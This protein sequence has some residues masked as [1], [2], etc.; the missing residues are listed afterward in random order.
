[1]P[2]K[3]TPPPARP[4][5]TSVPLTAATPAQALELPSA[6]ST[7]QH[8]Y[9]DPNLSITSNVD[10]QPSEFVTQRLKRR[11]EEH[12]IL[13]EDQLDDFKREMFTLFRELKAGQQAH[14]VAL[15]SAKVELS[16][17]N[18]K[19]QESVEF[20]SAKYDEVLEELRQNERER[21]ED[22]KYIKQLEEKIDF[23]EKRSRFGC[24]EIKNIPAKDKETK[25]DLLNTVIDLGKIVNIQIHPI[26]IK[27][28]FRINSKTGN[29]TIIAEFNSIIQK[30]KLIKSIIAFN[31]NKQRDDKLNS[32]HLHLNGPKTPIYVSH[33]LSAKTGRLF[34]LSRDFASTHNYKHCWTS[35]GQVYL[36]KDD[37]SPRIRIDSDSDLTALKSKN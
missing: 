7:S 26:D 37:Q 6:L 9:S 5:E 3:R 4:V 29:K 25:F 30:E 33:N 16:G 14:T 24:I 8:C 28:T 20:M 22:R 15:V 36:K 1:M 11:R 13:I 12:N 35:Y 18:S 2:L 17:Q 21:L 10:I 34:A 32:T 23:L 19:L 27:D 31:K